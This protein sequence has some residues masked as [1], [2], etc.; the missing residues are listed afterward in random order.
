M[1]NDYLSA[2]AGLAG[3]VNFNWLLIAGVFTR[4][5]AIAFLAPAMGELT[6][7]PR[8]RLAAAAALTMIVA[9]SL[10]ALPGVEV[11]AP[12]LAVLLAAEA[13]SGLLIGFAL[14]LAIF[15]LQMLG[16]IAA[17]A[18]SLTQLFGPGLG[19]DQ[20]SPFATILIAGGLA[21]ACAGGLHLELAATAAETYRALPFGEFI[22]FGDG[23]AFAATQASKALSLA[24]GLSAPF[25]L[26]GFAYSIALAASNRAMP[27]MAAV[28][29]GAPAIVLA[30][31]TLFAG[32]ASIILSRWSE[33]M[34][35]LVAAPLAGLP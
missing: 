30:G 34:A 24:F 5:S 1:A 7:S 11:N 15:A 28:F 18:L 26:L 21:L 33:T 25:V 2:I 13:A 9:P 17:Q 35:V 14:R 12:A 8:I 29:V 4:M 32:A 10:G 31:L 16:A 27:Q 6:V 19:H 23:A 20:E 22:A 3:H